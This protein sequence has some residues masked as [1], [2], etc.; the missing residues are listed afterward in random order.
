VSQHKSNI[1]KG[2]VCEVITFDAGQSDEDDTDV[3]INYTQIVD[4]MAQVALA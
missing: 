4:V 2:D 1:A 3:F